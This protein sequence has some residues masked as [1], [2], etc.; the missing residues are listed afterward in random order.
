MPKI[1]NQA[2]ERTST[3]WHFVFALC[4]HSNATRAPIEN[5]P[6]SAQLRATPTIPPK[7]HPGPCIA[8]VWA[9]SRRQTHR[10]THRRAWPLYI[11]RR[12]WLTRSAVKAYASRI[13]IICPELKLTTDLKLTRNACQSPAVVRQAQL[14]HP[15]KDT[16]PQRSTRRACCLRDVICNEGSPFRPHSAFFCSWWR[17]PLTFD[18]DIQTHTSQGPNTSSLWIWRTEDARK[19]AQR[20]LPSVVECESQESNTFRRFRAFSA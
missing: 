11:S 7:L 9:C 12:V 20:F 19:S 1:Y 6:N 15:G 3:H 10:Q 2:H 17:W 18:L 13:S 5:P 16:P 4:C 8:I 14:T